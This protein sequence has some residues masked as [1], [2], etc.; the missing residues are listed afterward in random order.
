MKRFVIVPGLK[1]Y[2]FNQ[3]K[4]PSIYIEEEK[5][6]KHSRSFW[7]LIQRLSKKLDL[8][9]I[10]Y[11]FIGDWKDKLL[12]CDC[13]IVFDQAFS[14][15]LVKCIKII[16][17]EIRVIVYLWNPTYK[18]ISIINKFNKIKHLISIYSFDKKDC[19][20]YGF[21]FSPMVYDFSLKCEEYSSIKY[22]VVFVGYLKNRANLLMQLYSKLR[23]LNITS[24]F[25]VLDDNKTN[26]AN[27][28]YP[29]DL[30][31]SYLEY[32][33]YKE[34]MIR[35]YAILDIVQANQV[36]LTIRTME[37]L[38]YNRKLITNNADIINYD[39]YRKNNVFVLGIDDIK[40]LRDFI[41]SPFEPI[42]WNTLEKYNFVNWVKAF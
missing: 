36:G 2:F 29:F 11:L 3:I 14:T 12:E 31:D 40:G 37:A 33:K 30:H 9:F 15:A 16:N 28:N 8:W 42:P 20:K 27:K 1:Y 41:Y 38:C 35:S 32:D 10:Y 25:Y 34:I 7:G 26:K 17:P 5:F 18:N 23:S 13:C 22:G 39:F 24:F 19:E 6:L 4:D 21:Y